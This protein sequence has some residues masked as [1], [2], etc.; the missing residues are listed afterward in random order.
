MQE[1]IQFI[2]VTPKELEESILTGIKTALEDLKENFQPKE[3][4]EYLTRNE[5]ASLLKV[6][7]STVHNWTK[8]NKLTSYGIGGRVFYKRKEVE[9]QIRRL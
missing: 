5:V 6:D 8:R 7:L 1:K 4:T 9:A 3:P 2:Q